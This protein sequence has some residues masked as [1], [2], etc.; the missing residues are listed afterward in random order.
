MRIPLVDNFLCCLKLETGG[1]IL[2]WIGSIG[3]TILLL[4]SLGTFGLVT[5][6]YASF[7][8]LAA[9]LEDENHRELVKS[10]HYCE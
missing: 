9:S 2:G 3:A 7:E 6:S 10:F 5:F 8:N 1:T 4:V